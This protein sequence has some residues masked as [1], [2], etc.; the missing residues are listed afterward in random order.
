MTL[1]GKNFWGIDND[2]YQPDRPVNTAE[3]NLIRN[4]FQWMQRQGQRVGRTYRR[5][6][7]QLPLFSTVNR[8]AF[9]Y[10]PIFIE[11]W[12]QFFQC[13]LVLRGIDSSPWD[14]TSDF[15]LTPFFYFFGADEIHYLSTKTVDEWVQFMQEYDLSS[16]NTNL[17]DVPVRLAGTVPGNQSGL[18]MVGVAM[19]LQVRTGLG[20]TTTIDGSPSEAVFTSTPTPTSETACFYRQNDPSL[21]GDLLLYDSNGFDT[22]SD[23]ENLAYTDTFRP[24]FTDPVP[25]Q[26]FDT[27]WMSPI[28]WSI[29]FDGKSFNAQEVYPR[30]YVRPNKEV[31]F[32]RGGG[33]PQSKARELNSRRRL[34]SITLPQ[35]DL[36]SDGGWENYPIWHWGDS[37]GE[38]PMIRTEVPHVFE[39]EGPVKGDLQYNFA[40]LPVR[41]DFNRQTKLQNSILREDDVDVTIESRS[42]SG[43]GTSKTERFQFSFTPPEPGGRRIL[44]QQ[45]F[46]QI[47][48]DR[49]TNSTTQ[50]Y[51]N[52]QGLLYLE[53]NPGIDLDLLQV[54]TITW[55]DVDFTNDTDPST[56]FAA[57]FTMPDP[58]EPYRIYLIGH[59]IQ[60]IKE[61]L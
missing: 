4:Q 12:K 26:W 58:G 48:T 52:S 50:R 45:A 34:S 10:T 19:E 3:D 46:L 44:T 24:N 36:P 39:Q 5:N 29:Q 53:D 22:T 15:E 14:W 21:Q 30:D 13:R 25:V 59:S 28:S 57:E 11:E 41:R 2:V 43:A 56:W 38:S 32:S 18:A 31:E 1:E 51:T 35:P 61:P 40:V 27:I 47:E 49:S 17:T 16:F 42:A 8:A 23:A 20:D 6:L 60:F 37:D 7:E 54:G 33:A 55:E 9:V